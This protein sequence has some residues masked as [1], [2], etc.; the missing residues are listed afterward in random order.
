MQT[1]SDLVNNSIQL[2]S[3]PD[4]YIRL[5]SVI[6]SPDTSMADVAQVISQDPSL[7]TRLLK[8]VNSPFYGFA[9]KIDTISHAINMLGTRQIHDLALATTVV[10]S[11]SGFT[12]EHLNIYDFWRNSVYCASNARLIAFYSNNIE[13]T[14]RPFVAGLLH[15]IG[16]LV[17]Y[18]KIPQ[19]TRKAASMAKEHEMPLFLAERELIGFDYAEVGAE[20]LSSLN[21][22]ESL[23][24]IT[25]YHNEPAKASDQYKLETTIVHIAT[26]ITDAAI[27]A[28]PVTEELEVAENSW[29]VTGLNPQVLPMVKQEADQQWQVSM[30][31][32]FT[33]RP[34]S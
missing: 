18:Q 26:Q 8:M 29:Q 28:K 2:I 15:D 12:N 16:H 23:K 11:F 6:D 13:T 34:G 14:E 17:M 7:T 31:L 21:L 3:L 10:N 24:Q 25:Q 22:P 4:A 19:E 9:S 5:K 33:K 30:D 20:L 27:A 1:A 32:I